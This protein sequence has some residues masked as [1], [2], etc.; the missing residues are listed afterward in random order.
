MAST[1]YAQRRAARPQII[2]GAVRP[3]PKGW[4]SWITTTDHKRIGILYLWT[5]LVFFI[6]GGVEAL[7]S[8]YSSAYPRTRCSR[9]SATTSCSPCTA[10]R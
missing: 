8:A 2:A 5:V 6:L 4:S 1:D 10:R 3:E 7:R 9:P